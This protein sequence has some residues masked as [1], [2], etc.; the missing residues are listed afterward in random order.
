MKS[1]SSVILM[2]ESGVPV[3]LANGSTF[4][5]LSNG[6]ECRDVNGGECVVDDPYLLTQQAKNDKD[7]L[8]H[9]TSWLTIQDLAEIM[10]EEFNERQ[11]DELAASAALA[12]HRKSER[13][14]RGKS[15]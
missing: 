15:D 6:D 7:Q 13:K 14:Q 4:R 9:L 3:S 11:W 1:L 10:M 12:H 5:L 8:V 2:L